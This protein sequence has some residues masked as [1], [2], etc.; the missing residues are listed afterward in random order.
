MNNPENLVCP[1]CKGDNLQHRAWVDKKG[2][3]VDYIDDNGA[4]CDD[5]EG[6]VAYHFTELNK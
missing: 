6:H 4:W 3:L 1:E 2:N 5:C